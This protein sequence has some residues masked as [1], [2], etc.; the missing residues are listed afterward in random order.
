MKGGSGLNSIDKKYVKQLDEVQ[1]DLF[2]VKN[3]FYKFM[4]EKINDYVGFVTDEDF[5]K[6]Y[7]ELQSKLSEIGEKARIIKRNWYNEY[8]LQNEENMDIKK[9]EIISKIIDDAFGGIEDVHTELR[10]K[11]SKTFDH[12]I[13]QKASGEIESIEKGL[14]E[15]KAYFNMD[16]IREHKR[17]YLEKMLEKKY[18]EL[19]E[20]C[21]EFIDWF[22]AIDLLNQEKLDRGEY[23]LD[24]ITHTYRYIRDKI[25]ELYPNSRPNNTRRRNNTR[26]P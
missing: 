19:M 22:G 10:K 17:P 1:G 6:K 8:D 9:E 3:Y 21:K 25:R 15:F 18:G 7:K 11:L 24:E 4:D 14:G 5:Q 12:T 13:G 23:L 2:E 16:L 20:E 26:T